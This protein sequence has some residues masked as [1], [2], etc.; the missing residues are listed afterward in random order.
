MS[1]GLHANKGD[2]SF[3]LGWFQQ[4]EEDASNGTSRRKL[5][6]GSNA[7]RAVHY[8]TQTQLAVAIE[9]SDEVHSAQ[10]GL[11]LRLTLTLANN[12]PMCES[13]E[14]SQRPCVEHPALRVALHAHGPTVPGCHA[15][16][17]GPGRLLD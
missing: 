16:G 14:T 11:T 3:L 17:H 15:H 1:D 5:E 9:A 10:H 12:A 6:A 13:R 2:L 7:T 4:Y 8:F